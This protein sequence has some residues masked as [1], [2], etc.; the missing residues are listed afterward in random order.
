MI[1][2]MQSPFTNYDCNDEELACK[3]LTSRMPQNREENALLVQHTKTGKT[4]YS[5]YVF[6]REAGQ[7][8]GQSMRDKVTIFF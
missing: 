7:Q 3:N 6:L 1:N 4:Y 8:L 2:A 5:D